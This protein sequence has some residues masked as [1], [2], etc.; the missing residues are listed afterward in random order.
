MVIAPGV[1]RE[2]AAP[3]DGGAIG[4]APGETVSTPPD[5]TVLAKAVPPGATSWWPV[6]TVR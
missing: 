5:A 1:E 3:F 2:G 6:I 4:G